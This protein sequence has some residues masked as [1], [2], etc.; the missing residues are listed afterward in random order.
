MISIIIWLLIFIIS[1]FVLIKASDFFTDAAEHIGLRFGLSPFIIGVTIV[2]VGTSL[3]ELFS[4]LIATVAGHT[5]IVIGN[6]VG[7]N[8][9]NIL[10]VLGV[11]AVFARKFTIARELIR[12]DLPLLV[13]ATFLAAL[14]MWDGL[15][16]PI[17]GIICLVLLVVYLVYTGLS[18]RGSVDKE[19]T[20]EMRTEIKELKEDGPELFELKKKNA[21]KSHILL[22]R[23][24]A[25]LLVSGVGIYFGAKYV[26]E[27]ILQLSI[28][29]GVATEVFSL[30]LV[31]LG[32][33]L[34]ELVVS[35]QAARKKKAEI[36]LG[37][38]LGSNIFNLLAVLSIPSF[39][40][41]LVVSAD[42]IAFSL[43]V[44]VLTTLLYMFIT[45]DREITQWE[46]ALLLIFY[47]YFILRLFGVA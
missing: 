9:A 16:T 44:L 12:V 13:G 26:V 37:N 45:Q 5:E 23:N 10:L 36:A 38:I 6:V 41:P 21:K 31:A 11:T 8:I 28:S 35:I 19:I 32:T 7:S 17:E 1:L 47:V 29:L 25:I 39:I 40:T 22:L 43:P 14:M 18:E 3:P 4:S 42:I 15:F 24:F 34:P 46:G 27:A 33:S 2:A 30:S 20:K